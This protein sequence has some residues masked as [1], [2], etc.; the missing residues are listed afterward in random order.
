M[1]PE[2]SQAVQKRLEG[3]ADVTIGPEEEVDDGL[4]L[5]WVTVRLNE[6]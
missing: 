6:R 1:T 4:S 3:L 5:P 2:V